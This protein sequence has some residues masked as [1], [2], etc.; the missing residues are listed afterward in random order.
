MITTIPGCQMSSPRK[1]HFSGDDPCGSTQILGR[2]TFGST[3][4]VIRQGTSPFRGRQHLLRATHWGVHPACV[5][6]LSLMHLLPLSRA[7]TQTNIFESERESHQNTETFI[8]RP[9]T[10]QHPILLLSA[11]FGSY[12]LSAQAFSAIF[13][14][15]HRST[16]PIRNSAPLAPYSRTMPRA[17][18]RT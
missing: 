3:Q 1:C 16:S 6:S 11:L 2:T 17:L 4:D 5:C 13:C 12:A 14:L 8:E 7:H 15:L 9:V 10:P 18:W